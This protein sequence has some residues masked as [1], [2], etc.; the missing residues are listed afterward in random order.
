MIS[1]KF[2]LEAKAAAFTSATWSLGK[3]ELFKQ[4]LV[5]RCYTETAD[6]MGP[7]R[8]FNQCDC[9]SEAA[10]PFSS[11]DLGAVA[12]YDGPMRRGN[13]KTPLSTWLGLTKC[14]AILT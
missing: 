12:F 6:R 8:R 13:I 3:A 11:A 5:Q 9:F 7:T 14:T 1:V 2:L 4:C 10:L